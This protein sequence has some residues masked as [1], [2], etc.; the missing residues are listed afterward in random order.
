MLRAAVI[1]LGVISPI[2]L[3]FIE[4]RAG[5]ELVAGCDILPEKAVHLP[6]GTAFYEDYKKL[7]AEV[8]PDIVHLC[9]PH[10][11]H[12]TVAEEALRQGAAVFC[13]KPV[14]STY[15]GAKRMAQLEQTY[16]GKI[17]ICFQ[18][19]YNPVNR[20]LAEVAR[21]GRYGRVLGV[22]GRVDWFRPAAYYMAS[23]WRGK[24]QEA[25]SGVILNQAIHTLDMMCLLKP[26]E[27]ETVSGS[28]MR[29]GGYAIEVEDTAAAEF[30][31][32]DGTMSYFSATV[33]NHSN[34]PVEMTVLTEQGML[35]LRGHQLYLD[36]EG[37]L[38][39]LHEDERATGAKFYYG[40]S[41]SKCIED[42]YRSLESGE[43]HYIHPQEALT[44]M[45]VYEAMRRSSEAG[46]AEICLADIA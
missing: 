21:S 10:Y 2:H 20:K 35:F 37:E 41:H 29:L 26:E 12:T 31:Y 24:L 36:V 22:K 3:Q 8:K 4:E 11:L 34:E 9:L 17:G 27:P 38:T 39:L 40:T 5:A 33:L 23:P 16:G 14:S 18:N 32:R 28:L 7:L 13:E 30:R 6:A 46:G 43:D 15:E 45:K 19:R 25:G 44:A 42:F 1:G